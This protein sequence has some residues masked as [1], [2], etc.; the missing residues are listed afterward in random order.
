MVVDSSGATLDTGSYL[1]VHHRTNG[2]WLYIRDI[3]NSDRPA[4]P[5]S[6]S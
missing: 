6:G 5:P 3:W 1:S 4:A 2:A